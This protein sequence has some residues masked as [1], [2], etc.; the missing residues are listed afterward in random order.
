MPKPGCQGKFH[1]LP[2][3]NLNSFP[4]VSLS[5]FNR[6]PKWLYLEFSQDSLP[7]FPLSPCDKRGQLL[8]EPP[9]HSQGFP[10]GSAGEEPICQ[11]RR[12]KRYRFDCWVWK[13]PCRRKWQPTLVFLPG[14]F[15]GWRGLVGTVHGV[16]KSWTQLSTHVLSL[17]KARPSGQ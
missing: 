1:E 3:P 9:F 4:H 10:G 8:V 11:C 13:I 7:L 12:H 15:H 17:S 6:T 16:T 2:F 14:K 5:G